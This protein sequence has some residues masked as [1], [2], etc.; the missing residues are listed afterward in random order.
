MASGDVTLTN[1]GTFDVSGAAL[2][3][4]VDS[5]NLIKTLSGAAIYIVPV[6]LGQVQVLQTAIE[7]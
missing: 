2:K 7:V 5:L 6:E 1:H 4:K 3:T